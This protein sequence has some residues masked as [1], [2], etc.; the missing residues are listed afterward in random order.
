MRI[1]LSSGIVLLVA[2]ITLSGCETLKSLP[3]NTTSEIFSLNGTWQ[4]VAT[5]DNNAL[6]GSTVIVYPL[7]GN[8]VTKRIDNNTYCIRENDQ[9]WKSLK[10]NS[11]GGF[12][13]ST[14]INAC[15]GSK[16]YKEAVISVVNNDKISVTSRTMGNTELVQ[17]W[18]RVKQPQ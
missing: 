7:V 18:E 13:M 9:L 12:S 2:L 15:D 11:A 4:L 16:L 10:S 3:T 6:V 5:T 8:G 17:S 1:F 14:L